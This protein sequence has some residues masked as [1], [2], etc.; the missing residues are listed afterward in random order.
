[1]HDRLFLVGPMGAGKTSIGRL[2]AAALGYEFIDSDR[3]IEE[4][5]GVDIP[6][7]FYYEGETGFRQRECEIIDELTQC[8]K[9]ILATG[10]G[11]ILKP[12]N[13]KHLAS[14]GFVVHLQVSINEQLK[15]TAKDQSR[16]LLQVADPAAKLN[17]LA[18]ERDPLYAE[19]ADK[20]V[21]TNRGQM[22]SIKH[23]I[24]DAFRHQHSS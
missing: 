2:V 3:V 10:G 15:R 21:D 5:T 6:T 22:H 18:I 1:M 11:A 4:T 8:R 24:V 14:R 9:I 19:I 13:R 17:Q 23:Q 20:Q 12:E 16:P 7:I